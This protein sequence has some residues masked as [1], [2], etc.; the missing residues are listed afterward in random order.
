MPG[1]KPT[2]G[3]RLIGAAAFQSAFRP[4]AAA[5]HADRTDKPSRSPASAPSCGSSAA[6][7]GAEKS[8]FLRA[9]ST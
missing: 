7:L 5:Y 9:K 4:P 8:M 3:G 2:A 6:P 1:D